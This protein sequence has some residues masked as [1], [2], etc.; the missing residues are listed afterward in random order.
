MEDGFSSVCC[1]LASWIPLL[2]DVY[3]LMISSVMNWRYDTKY[4]NHWNCT[5]ETCFWE[6]RIQLSKI[7]NHWPFMYTYLESIFAAKLVSYVLTQ[8]YSPLYPAT[9]CVLDGGMMGFMDLKLLTWFSSI[10]WVFTGIT[11]RA[12][13]RRVWSYFPKWYRSAS[14]ILICVRYFTAICTL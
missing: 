4:R 10:C 12:G 9:N 7:L 13:T 5:Y 6:K 11:S 1:T 2:C 3:T 8:S 14:S